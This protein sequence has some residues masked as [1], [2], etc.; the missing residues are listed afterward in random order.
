MPCWTGSPSTT[1]RSCRGSPRATSWCVPCPPRAR[2]A[3]HGCGV[4]W[5]GRCGCGWDGQGGCGRGGVVHWL[6]GTAVP[7]VPTPAAPA[8]HPQTGHTVHIWSELSP[9]QGTQFTPGRSSG[10]RAALRPC[11]DPVTWPASPALQEPEWGAGPARL[12]DQGGRSSRVTV[13][14]QRPEGLRGR[15]C[16]E[17]RGRW[18]RGVTPSGGAGGRERIREMSVAVPDARAPITAGCT[19]SGGSGPF[20]PRRLAFPF[21]AHFPLLTASK[22]QRHCPALGIEGRIR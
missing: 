19:E 13:S 20:L 8:G 15:G 18:R 9:R 12:Q 16:G 7:C 3:G 21:R 5:T 14:G 1:T 6:Q 10:G 22:C 17:V 11:T 4:V 2:V